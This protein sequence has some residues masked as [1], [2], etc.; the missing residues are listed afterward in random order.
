MP[1][2]IS[3]QYPILIHEIIGLY[4]HRLIYQQY[5]KMKL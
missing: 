3:N 1:K 4:E 5:S 2:I